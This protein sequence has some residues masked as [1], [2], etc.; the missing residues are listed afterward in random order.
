MPAATT[1]AWFFTF[2][3]ISTLANM[4]MA[5]ILAVYS[6]GV[7]DT[8]LIAIAFTVV[9]AW[10]GLWQIVPTTTA[11]LTE[12]NLTKLFALWLPGALA[13]ASASALMWA[14]AR[15][16]TIGLNFALLAAAYILIAG[17]QI[18]M[19]AQLKRRQNRLD[20]LMGYAQ[21]YD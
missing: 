6:V 7:A 15:C 4:G 14:A 5:A 20:L 3:R 17:W 18:G 9:L 8:I 11:N 2:A 19:N 10:I 21:S 13:V 12:L 1:R 16:S